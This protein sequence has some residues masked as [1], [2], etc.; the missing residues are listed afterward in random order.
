MHIAKKTHTWLKEIVQIFHGAVIMNIYTEPPRHY[1]GYTIAGKV[2][3]ILIP[4][5]LGK[6]GYMKELGDKLSLRGHPVYIIPELEMNIFS[7]PFSAKMLRALVIRAVP[8]PFH[9]QPR[10]I[11]GAETVRKFIEQKNLKGAI[12]VAHSKGG[13]IGKYLLS[14]YN[15]DHRVLGMVTIST[16]FAG[17]ALAKFIPHQ[18]FKELKT[19]SEIIADLERHKKTNSQIISVFPEFDTH[20][21]SKSGSYLQGAADNIQ[22]PVGGHN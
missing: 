1:L 6:W 2:P 10:V 20:I 19:D 4:G 11:K 14:H 13:L 3:V 7:I 12:I 18:A 15:P 9:V 5:I 17:S 22:V 21:W 16:P 8:T